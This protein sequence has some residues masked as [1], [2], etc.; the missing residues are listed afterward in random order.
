MLGQFLELNQVKQVELVK[1]LGLDK[2]QVS[3]WANDP[4][5]NVTRDNIDKILA[6]LS[7]RLGRT[8]TYEESFGSRTLPS[9]ANE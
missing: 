4:D 2:A 6:W 8:V 5:A 3:R 1:D 7:K 9:A